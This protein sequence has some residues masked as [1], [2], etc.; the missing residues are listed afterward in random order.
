M[1][2]QAYTVSNLTE[3][4]DALSQC[5]GGE[6]IL[7]SEGSY[8]RLDLYDARHAFATFDSEVTIMSASETKAVFTGLSLYGVTN[9][10]F[11]SV[12]F[13]YTHPDG[14]AL[15]D[16]PFLVQNSDGVKFIDSDFIGDAAGGLGTVDDGYGA[17]TG[18]V[19]RSSSNVE[20]T[21]NYFEMFH[22]GLTVG[23]SQNIVVADNEFTAM[24]S[25]GMNFAEVQGV[26]IEGNYLHDFSKHP[27]SPAHMDMIQFWT[28]GTDSPST[29]IIIRDN[30]LIRGEG[31]ETQSIF[32]RNEA[33]DSYG[34]GVEM[35]YSNVLIENN[36]IYNSHL[37]GITVG[38]ADGLTIQNNTLL[39][40]TYDGAVAEVNKPA[41]SVALAST[42]VSILNNV[43]ANEISANASAH[44]VSDNL[45]LQRDFVGEANHYDDYYFNALSNGAFDIGDLTPAPGV[46]L[47]GIGADLGDFALFLGGP[48]GSFATNYGDG[49]TALDVSF[50][51]VAVYDAGSPV[52]L[53]GAT[54]RWLVDGVE[55]GQDVTLD[56]SFA[57][58]GSHT[59]TLEITPSGA[60][61]PI[62]ID[63]VV[64]VSSPLTVLLQAEGGVLADMSEVANQVTAT[65]EVALV[66]DA[67]KG[68]VIDLNGGT[69]RVDGT[70]DMIKN[71]EFTLAFDFRSDPALAGDARVIDFP[72]SFTVF[73]TA[74]GFAV[75]LNTSSGGYWLK[76]GDARIADGGWHN[77]E[78]SFSGV[79]GA[80]AVSIDGTVVAS[81]TGLEGASQ[82][83]SLSHDLIIGDPWG[84]SNF[85]GLIGDVVLASAV[86]DLSL[87]T[88][89]DAPPPGD[90][91][92]TPPPPPPEDEPGTPPP[93]EDEPDT[94]PP[95]PEDPEDPVGDPPIIVADETSIIGTDEGETLRWE[96]GVV[97]MDGRG[98][99]DVIRA[100]DGAETVLGGDGDDALAGYS[101]DDY[102]DGGEGVDKINAGDG[103]DVIVFD[104]ND[105][106]IRG[107]AGYDQLVFLTAE[108]QPARLSDTRMLSGIDRV[109]L[110]NGGAD[111][112]I[113]D[114]KDVIRGTDFATLDVLG[115]VGDELTLDFNAEIIGA[116]EIDGQATHIVAFN[117]RNSQ[118][119]IEVDMDVKIIDGSGEILSL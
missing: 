80:A 23:D 107:G 7:L 75:A 2:T 11:Q 30:L 26:L 22:R 40:S 36:I 34:A 20:I 56:Y 101:G 55:A 77:F 102:L 99:D 13:E 58:G 44:V 14:V 95:P 28:S 66:A 83:G 64:E 35:Y 61:A 119:Q 73:F 54:Y 116:G 48:L 88:S 90:E 98:G 12:E 62:V 24:S 63:K 69:V 53:D 46:D 9:L 87:L 29:D 89:P 52:S 16:K 79:T 45:V 104:R 81:V 3:L 111:S 82:I 41:I 39:Q 37:H 118:L 85:E 67:E 86:G 32:M 106:D 8:G 6:T 65:A 21:G 49:M 19:I 103:D 33:V 112:L 92:D 10:T 115:D 31:D 15:Y 72:G 76:G 27:D 100:G 1:S 117:Y 114:A 38:E 60:T 108:A 71:D 42:G 109:D 59:V 68:E 105:N 70:A 94:P 113:L 50:S 96:P 93:P 78:L 4:M 47:T 5:T 91:P 84:K 17:G 25:D 18:L 43:V 57:T 74:T 97:Y 110:E 51:G